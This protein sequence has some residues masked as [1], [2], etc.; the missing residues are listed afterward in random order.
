MRKKMLAN[1]SMFVLSWLIKNNAF[2]CYEENRK[3]SKLVNLDENYLFSGYNDHNSFT[4][5]YYYNHIFFLK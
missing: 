3:K 2:S 4:L 1:I 5:F